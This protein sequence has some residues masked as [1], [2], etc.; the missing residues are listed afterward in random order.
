MVTAIDTFVTEAGL[1]I[2]EQAKPLRP[3]RLEDIRVVCWM[4]VAKN[5]T[6]NRPVTVK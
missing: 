3:V 4:A 1:P 5:E 6:S 2:L